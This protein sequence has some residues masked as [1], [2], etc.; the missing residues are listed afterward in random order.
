ML[1]EVER[2]CGRVALL[3]KGEMVLLTSVRDSRRLAPRRVR[4]FFTED[5]TAVPELP[6]GHELI[7]NTARLWRL[8]VAGPLGPLLALLEGLPVEDMELDEARL[9]DVVLKYYRDEA[10]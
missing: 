9:E 4:V 2:V 6:P 5:V 8:T 1:S 3:R 10:T 7:E